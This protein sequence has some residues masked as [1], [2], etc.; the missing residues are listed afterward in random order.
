MYEISDFGRKFSG[1]T[2]IGE[3]MDDLADAVSSDSDC[4]FMGGG[5]P[6]NIAE[7][8]VIF[9]EKMNDILSDPG[10][11]EAIVGT[12]DAPQGK[13][14]FLKLVAS[15]FNNIYG[16]GIT[17]KNIAVTNGSQNAFFYL[18]NMLSG[19][20]PGGRKKKIVLPIV[21]EYIGYADQGLDDDIFKSFLPKINYTG[22]HRFKYSI[23]FDNLKIDETTGALCITRPT[24]PTGNVISDSELDKLLSCCVDANVPLILDNAYGE[25]FPGIIFKKTK[26]VFNENVILSY[27]LSKLGLPA[28]RTGIVI[29]NEKLIDILS[30]I[31]AVVNLATGSFGQSLAAPLF[32]DKLISNISN[33]IIKPYY[34]ERSTLCQSLIKKYFPDDINYYVHESEGAFFLWIWFKG[35]PVTSYELYTILKAKG[36]YVIPGHYFFPGIQSVSYKH[37]CIRITFTKDAE[38]MARGIATIADEIKNLYRGVK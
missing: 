31:N 21:P 12:Y 4:V 3:L 34:L 37:E 29:A 24:N 15:F 2:G 28:L 6:A 27:S 7:V 10:S 13:N 30:N 1:P 33:D 23:D 26:P 25:P 38:S 11:F 8:Q 35:L 22:D 9:R 16:W 19:G 17:E 18:F 20:Y 32:I 36:V 14:S 5:N